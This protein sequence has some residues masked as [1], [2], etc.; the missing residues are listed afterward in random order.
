[1]P[2]EHARENERVRINRPQQRARRA[3]RPPS[4]LLPISQRFEIDSDECCEL[5][6]R[7]SKFRT[8]EADVD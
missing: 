8:N 1:M 7:G 2:I 4:S 3:V 5:L 6:L